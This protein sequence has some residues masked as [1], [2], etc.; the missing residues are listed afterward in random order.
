MLEKENLARLAMPV[1]ARVVLRKLVGGWLKPCIWG[2]FI[3]VLLFLKQELIQEF[4]D[5]SKKLR[6][7]ES[8]VIIRVYV[9]AV[10]GWSEMSVELTLT[11]LPC[12]L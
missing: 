10:L 3:A 2:G 8:F 11:L 4:E 12:H 5:R 1:E 7:R 6:S 9:A